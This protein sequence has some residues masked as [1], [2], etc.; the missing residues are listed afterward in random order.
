MIWSGLLVYFMLAAEL[1][2][3]VYCNGSYTAQ[4]HP[5]IE[6]CRGSSLCSRKRID[7]EMYK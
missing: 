7:S 5:E 3:L 6:G 1:Q 2:P 4:M